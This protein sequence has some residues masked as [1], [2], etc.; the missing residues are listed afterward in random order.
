MTLLSKEAIFAQR[1]IKYE[2]VEVPEWGGAVRLRSLTG[3]ERDDYEASM[4][5]QVGNKAKANLRNM[6][7][8][9]V[10]LSA[11]NE[12]GSPL[13]DPADL[14]RLGQ[15]NSAALDRLFEAC[16]RLSGL[17]ED[18]VKEL[19]EGFAPAPNGAPISGSLSPSAAQLP[20]SSHAFP[21]ANSLSG[22]HTNA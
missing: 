9:L 5:R 18:D 4:V 20:N 3:E 16:Q 2:D 7:A 13:F 10:A 19:E 22:S 6:R 14:M 17:S 1:D 12:D 8:K 15:R 21:A 11:V